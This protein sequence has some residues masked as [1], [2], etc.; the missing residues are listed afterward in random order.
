MQCSW[1]GNSIASYGVLCCTMWKTCSTMPPGKDLS[2]Q[3]HFPYEILSILS[4]YL[5]HYHGLI[6]LPQ[7]QIQ[8][9][10]WNK[11]SFLY[12]VLSHWVIGTSQGVFRK[13][14][15]GQKH[16]PCK[17]TQTLQDLN[18]WPLRPSRREAE[19]KRN[20]RRRGGGRGGRGGG[21]GREE[22]K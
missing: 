6:L 11:E 3:F 13:V 9:N 15:T 20:R 8:N 1:Y 16:R 18:S 5:I 17:Y 19:D 10:L 12:G 4:P 2:G 21:G 22:D 14:K 7:V